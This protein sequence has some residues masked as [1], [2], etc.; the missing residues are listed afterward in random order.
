MD[1]QKHVAKVL[2]YGYFDAVLLENYSNLADLSNFDIDYVNLIDRIIETK[3]RIIVAQDYDSEKSF[4]LFEALYKR[5]YKPG[6]F[7][8]IYNSQFFDL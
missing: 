2:G 6:D 5:G 4:K 8:P 7:I 1:L 3:V